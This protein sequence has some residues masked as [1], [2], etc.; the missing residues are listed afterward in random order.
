M[1]DEQLNQL[2]QQHK[3]RHK[4]T[5]VERHLIL[6]KARQA[7]ENHAAKSIDPWR[8][9]LGVS[10]CAGLL[11]LFTLV[12]GEQGWQYGQQQ[13]PMQVQI[14]SLNDESGLHD[15]TS[16]LREK[17]QAQKAYHYARYQQGQQLLAAHHQQGA[18]LVS[19]E[20]GWEFQTC[21]NELLVL[22][23]ALVEQMQNLQRFD[24]SLRNGDRVEIQFDQ[25]GRIVLITASAAQAC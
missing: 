21:E 13:S 2:Y 18:V 3:K 4:T 8:W 17:T 19:T 6:T 10:L 1:S 23:Q 14:H 7:Q 20:N 25:Q 24:N 11:V 5:K 22:T 9:T 16:R 15:D 12:M